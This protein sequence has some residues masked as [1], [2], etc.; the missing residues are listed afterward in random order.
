MAIRRT[1][2]D[3]PVEMADAVAAWATAGRSVLEEVAGKYGAYI[4]YAELGGKLQQATGIETS[5]QLQH[6]IG[7]VLTGIEEQ[8]S[9]PDEPLLSSL[10]VRADESVGT[11]YSLSVAARDGEAPGDPDLHAAEERH[12]CYRR[13]GAV[14]P[15]G[16]GRPKLTTAVAARRAKAKAKEP[17]RLPVCPECFITLPATGA[18]DQHGRPT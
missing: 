15:N 6:W 7:K 11:G 4:S 2:D 18:C 14:L 16:G 9:G 5:Q 10:V 8:R 13:Y 12:R 17:V 3:T 1:T